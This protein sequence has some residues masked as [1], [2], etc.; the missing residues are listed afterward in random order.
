[1]E[2]A[3]ERVLL[4]SNLL[5]I[6]VATDWLSKASEEVYL[7]S[8]IP[9]SVHGADHLL[10]LFLKK[11][12]RSFSTSFFLQRHSTSITQSKSLGYE[13]DCLK[14]SGEPPPPRSFCRYTGE[15]K[16]RKRRR[17]DAPMA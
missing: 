13:I 9:T 5:N 3:K 15:V 11:N 4:I 8:S 12:E 7:Y 2:N 6:A 17:K 14:S 16:Q 1:M 10:H